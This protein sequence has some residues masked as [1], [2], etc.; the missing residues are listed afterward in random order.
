MVAGQGLEAVRRCHFAVPQQG[1]Y[2][3]RFLLAHYTDAVDLQHS[4]AVLNRFSR[5]P[6]DDYLGA[7]GFCLSLS[8]AAR[9]TA[10]PSTV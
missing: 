10:S 2:V 5:L 7:V 1:K 3:F 6:A 4:Q 8:R 9:L